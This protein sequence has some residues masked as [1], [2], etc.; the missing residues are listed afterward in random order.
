MESD[1]GVLSFELN[2]T[3][4]VLILNLVD[5]MIIK[6]MIFF[7]FILTEIAFEIGDEHGELE[8]MCKIGPNT[9]I[10]K[11]SFDPSF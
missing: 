8:T 6:A 1:A 11:V 5:K 3:I 4:L 9:C 10:L 7:L 2:V